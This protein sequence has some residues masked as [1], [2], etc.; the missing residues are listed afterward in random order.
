MT[1]SSSL[2]IRKYSLEPRARKYVKGCEFLSF[3]RK[4]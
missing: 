2:A 1:H 3:A 4:Y